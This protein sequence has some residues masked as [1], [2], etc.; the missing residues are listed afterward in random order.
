MKEEIT[1]EIKLETYVKLSKI[2][3][4]HNL[5]ETTMFQIIDMTN[6]VK[7]EQSKQ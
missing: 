4:T 7:Y 5:E 2:Q 6:A 1:S 3:F